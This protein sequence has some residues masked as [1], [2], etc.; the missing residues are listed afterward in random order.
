MLSPIAI[1]LNPRAGKHHAGDILQTITTTLAGKQIAFDVFTNE[2]PD[3]YTGYAAIWLI[4]GDGTLNYFINHYP[5]V[6]LPLALFKGGTGNDFATHLYGKAGTREM[7]EIILQASPQPVDAGICNGQLFVNTIGIGF[8][9]EVLKQMNT[10]RWLGGTIGYYAAIIRNIFTFREPELTI[11]VDKKEPVRQSCLLLLISNAPTT[12]GG[13]RVSPEASVRDGYLNL[14]FCR[15][16][17]RLRRIGFLPAV[18][19][20]AHLRYRFVT[21]QPVKS[22]TI[23]ANQ[24]LAAQIDG[25]LV[26]GKTFS[27]GI[28]PGHCSFLYDPAPIP[29][30]TIQRM[31]E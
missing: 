28:L 31:V 30:N 5:E 23:E 9:G 12:G 20:G 26:Y 15:P 13:F 18:R 27:C 4:G 3:H 24:T 29:P 7:I 6:K 21:H 1:L 17:N 14:I 2:W 19:K 25:E 22:C 16:L 8:D 10:I 11:A